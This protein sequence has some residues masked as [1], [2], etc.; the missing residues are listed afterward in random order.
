MG[1]GRWR[2]WVGALT[3][4]GGGAGAYGWARAREGG[5]AR[6]RQGGGGGRGGQV[7]AI[8]RL[9]VVCLMQAIP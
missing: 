7:Q 2:A 3:R 1:G 6:A 9:F 4:G 8:F 5:G